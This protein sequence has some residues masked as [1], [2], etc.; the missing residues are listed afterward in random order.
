MRYL[1][2]ILLLLTAIAAQAQLSITD[3]TT[4]TQLAQKLVGSGVTISNV[5]YSGNFVSSGIFKSI[6]TVVPF[7]SGI[8]LTSGIARTNGIEIGVDG[9][10][11]RNA[12]NALNGSGDVDLNVL[13]NNTTF[14]ATVLE[15][16]IAPLGDTLT[17]NYVFSSDEYPEYNCSDFNDVFA[18]FISG[19]GIVG[20]Q[21]LAKIPNTNI[22]VAINSINDGTVTGG[23]NLS[24]CTSLGP[25]SPFVSLYIKNTT[26]THLTHN[27]L[28]KLLTAKVVVQPCQK[29]HLKIAI[30]DAS[31]GVIDSGVFIEANSLNSNTITSTA[32]GNVDNSTGTKYLAEGCLGSTVQFRIPAAVATPTVINLLVAGTATNGVDATLVPPTITIPAGA[33]AFNLDINAFNDAFTEG[34]EVLKIYVPTPCNSGIFYDSAI[35]DIRDYEPLYVTPD[36]SLVCPTASKQLIA[37]SGYNTYTWDANPTLSST[38]IPNPVATPTTSP[39][40]YYCTAVLGTCTAR[41]SATILFNNITLKAKQDV[42]CNNGNTGSILVSHGSGWVAPLQFTINGGTPQAD[43]LFTGLQVGTYIIAIKDA[44]NCTSNITVSIIQ[45]FPN[46]TLTHTL[47]PP[48][49]SIPGAIIITASGGNA[50]YQYSLDGIAYQAS[51]SLAV[52]TNGNYTVYV[53]DGNGC[54]ATKQVV[55][56]APSN[57]SFTTTVTPATCSGLPDGTI[58]ITTTTGTS[59]YTYSNNGG[60][61]FQASNVFNMLSTP[62]VSIVV[63]DALGCSA[64]ATVSVPLTNAVLVNAGTP[65]TLCEGNNITSNAT[66]NGTT[67]NWTPSLGVSNIA[68]LNPTLAPTTTTKY[69]ITATTGICNKVDSVLITVNPAPIP[70]A[71]ADTTICFGTAVTL[72][73]TG[74]VS[75]SWKPLLNITNPNTPT[76]TVQPK[77]TTVY[78][79]QVTDANGCKSLIADSIRVNITPKIILFAGND[80][81]VASSQPI[82]LNAISNAPL[83]T[84]LPG[85]YLS[86]AAIPNP[87]AVFPNLGVYT[88]SVTAYT[89][90][91]CFAVDSITI[92]VYLG[93]AIYIPTAFSP[94]GDGTND[95]LYITTVGIK[96]IAYFEIYNRWGQKVFATKTSKNGWNGTFKNL[97]QP[98]GTYVWQVKGT[99]YKGNT[100]TQKGTL[101]LIK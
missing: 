64:L 32:L 48:G 81:L 56:N 19:P 88:Y 21:N 60:V 26:G 95:V 91:G 75:Y 85:T 94:N 7:D 76:P 63:K 77:D 41:D 12:D 68:V 25:G 71:G 1:T 34:T 52:T 35:I 33:T 96:D 97:Q 16:D 86:N 18:F 82:Q 65:T 6:A 78:Y 38:T 72:L 13:S 14:D 42:N 83:Y 84:W 2:I 31:D 89:P 57:V 62:N 93:P 58:T 69:Y 3:V 90:Q 50:A 10:A 80:T 70:N 43:S 23:N 61:S 37:S 22:P 74:G 36:T 9:N 73:A 100:I 11:T 28:T 98:Q 49:C 87:I 39:T 15:F 20:V 51:N 44:T 46:L 24:D 40:T 27:G 67:Y 53:K 59:P 101:Q 54:I 99:D 5:T 47:I 55:V 45:A 66:S 79:V 29:Y 4:A 92:T 17:F 30:A 8:V